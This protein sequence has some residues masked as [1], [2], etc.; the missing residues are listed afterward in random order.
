[1]NKT[2][3]INALDYFLT[4]IIIVFLVLSWMYAY[5]E[6]SNLPER[7]VVHFDIQGN[8]DGYNSK[9]S[10]WTA[11]IIFTLLSLG[12][13]FGTFYPDKIQFP[14]REL[15]VLERIATK[16][17]MFFSGILLSTLLLNIV[18]SMITT[19]LN[20]TKM[21][22]YTILIIGVLLVTYLILVFYY[23]NKYLKK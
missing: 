10:I 17:I 23:K 4:I 9:Q 21:S 12:C 11:P 22:G 16:K 2:D 3:K 5:S 19:S 15:S 6:Y 8:P 18:Y 1:M 7:I 13:I 20:N 14:K